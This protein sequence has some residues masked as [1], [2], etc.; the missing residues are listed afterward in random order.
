M[1]SGRLIAR[2]AGRVRTT[3]RR[4]HRRAEGDHRPRRCSA[5]VVGG[6]LFTPLGQQAPAGAAVH[7]PGLGRRRAPSPRSSPPAASPYELAD[8][9][10]TILVPQDEVYQLRLDLQRRRACPTGGEAAATRCSTSRASPPR[11][12]S[13]ASTTSGRSRA[14]WPRPS[15]SIDGVEAAIVHLVIPEETSSP[16]DSRSPPRSV[17]VKDTRRRDADAGQVQAIVHLVVLQRRGPR[18]RARHRRRRQGR[19]LSGAGED[20]RVGARR[21]PGRAD[22]GL[23][24]P[25][26][27]RSLAG[28]CSTRWSA[29]ATRSCGSTP[30]S[31]STRARP[32][33]ETYRRP[34]SRR[35]PSAESTATEN[36][37]GTGARRSAAC[38]A[39]TTSSDR[40]SAGDG[41]ASKTTTEERRRPTRVGKVTE[42]ATSAPGAVR[43]LSVAVLLDERDAA[44]VDHAAVQDLVSAAAG[45]D[46]GPRR[47]GRRSAA[48]AV[49][50]ERR[51]RGG[52]GRRRA[53]RRP[54]RRP[55][56][57]RSVRTVA[58]CWSSASW[59]C[60]PCASCAATG[61][62]ALDPSSL[63]LEDA[64]AV[65]IEAEE[66][67]AD[68]RRRQE[69]LALEA[70]R[71]ST[72]RATPS[73]SPVQDEVGRAGRA[74][75][76][77]GRAAAARLARGPEDLM[78]M[79][80][81]LTGAAEG[82][83]PA[84]AAGPGALGR[85]PRRLRETEVEE[86]TAEIAR[87]E[88]ASPTETV[89]RGASRSSRPSSSARRY[90]AQGGIGLRPRG[91]RGDRSATSG[92]RRSWTGCRPPSCE[93]PFQ[94]LRRADARQ[95]LSF[96]QDEH[97]QTIALVLA[98]MRRRPGRDRAVRPARDLQ[99]D[100]A[101]RIAIMDRTSPEIITPGRGRSS[102]ASCRSVLQSERL[103]DRRRPPAA[104]RHHQPRRP[105][106]RA[107]HP[108]GPRAPRPGAG[109][110]GPQPDVHVRG[111]HHPRRPLGAAGA[112]P[113]RD[114]RPRHRAQGRQPGR[115]RQDHGATCPSA[116]PPTSPTRS[117]CSARCAS[118]PVEEAQAED[119]RRSSARSRSPA[120]SW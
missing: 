109:R 34:T 118:A 31:T 28:R 111:H 1:P 52:G 37:T 100:V 42:Q 5:L 24:G 44:T 60:S 10:S 35:P 33:T 46:A 57:G 9:G 49:R 96:L 71:P 36:Y 23:R 117:S 4:L 70:R 90:Y 106:H 3:A 73:A 76:R 11:S 85:G 69:R 6:V 55:S 92:P 112:A 107:A 98:H 91:A 15:R 21:R 79:A 81:E 20:G 66:A 47:H 59:C 72:P 40:D 83:R 88:A 38:S 29:P 120:R 7:Q 94:F 62:R 99:A 45:V 22:P 119:R 63:E 67:G 80:D 25:S 19:V 51:G 75:A 17:L 13:S 53:R 86:L 65:P 18:A 104:G 108:R 101:H 116:R 39:R 84:R 8:G 114:R 77:R 93:M 56:D 14:S 61:A 113:G 115:P 97:P 68:A 105:R 54:R 43:R 95:L 110:R 16:S 2:V 74:P 78:P 27:R 30:T 87:I 82:G 26:C 89:G 48:M 102:S 50:P 41:D 32:T 103:V 12:S 58:V 64:A